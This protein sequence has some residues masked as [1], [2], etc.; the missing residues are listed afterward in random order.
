MKKSTPKCKDCKHYKVFPGFIWCECHIV[1][2]TD[3]T[4]TLAGVKNVRAD[5]KL[6]GPDG[7]WWEPHGR[8]LKVL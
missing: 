4:V 6:C 1:K 5:E 3:G 8:W 2:N 7:R